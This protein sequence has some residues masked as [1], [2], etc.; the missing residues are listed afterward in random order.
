MSLPVET[1]KKF[2][3]GYED[4]LVAITGS[5]KGIGYAAAKLFLDE[6]ATVIVNGRSQESVDNAL[7]SLKKDTGVADEKVI[8]VPADFSTKEGADT[9]NAEVEK[10]GVPDV[11]VLNAGIYSIDDFFT[12]D[13]DV[14]QKYFDVNV[15]STI[16]PARFFL[17]KLIERNSGNIIVTSSIIG[18]A[19]FGIALPYA[20]SKGSQ[21]TIARGLAELTKGTKVRVNGVLPGLTASDGISGFLAGPAQAQGVD[22]ETA[23][24]GMTASQ[25]VPRPASVGEIADLILFLGSERASY[26]NGQNIKADGGSVA[27]I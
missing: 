22:I 26:I 11:L 24:Q 17:P 20:F 7:A 3:L 2:T 10:V 5:T 9:F 15:M 4:K 12:T 25:L 13:D 23:A 21:L 16:R 18:V 8:G 14:W 27:H 1:P 6:G 19:P